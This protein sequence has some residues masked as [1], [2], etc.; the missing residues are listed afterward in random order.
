MKFY[1]MTY[2][3]RTVLFR[4]DPTTHDEAVW[5]PTAKAWAD[6]D[7][8]LDQQIFAGAPYVDTPPEQA[9]AQFPDAFSGSQ[10]ATPHPSDDFG[11]L[12]VEQM[13]SII[14]AVSS[15]MDPG[16]WGQAQGETLSDSDAPAARRFWA[17]M[18]EEKKNLKPGETMMPPA[19]WS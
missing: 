10:D 7:G 2:P 12:T 14:A 15:G 9:K 19:E 4:L 8:F 11:A 6:S 16:A 3:S 18:V 5:D 17:A 1:T 13:A